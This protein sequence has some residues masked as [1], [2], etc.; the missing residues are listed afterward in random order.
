MSWDDSAIPLDV[1]EAWTT[2]EIRDDPGENVGL[3]L[4]MKSGATTFKT[5]NRI[6]AYCRDYAVGV[7]GAVLIEE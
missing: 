7:V 2:D 6:A 4:L 5:L 1:S 3:V